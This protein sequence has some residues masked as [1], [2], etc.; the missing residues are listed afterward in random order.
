MAITITLTSDHEAWILA[1]VANDE[2]AS[3]EEPC[4]SS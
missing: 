3:V 4:S 2:F 1:Q